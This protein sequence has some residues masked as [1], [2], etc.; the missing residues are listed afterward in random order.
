[1]D[2][3]VL[4]FF[5]KRHYSTGAFID[6]G[7]MTQK[8]SPDEHFMNLSACDKVDP[9]EF[10]MN[11]KV[12]RGDMSLCEIYIGK[13]F[14]VCARNRPLVNNGKV[15]LCSEQIVYATFRCTCIDKRLHMLDVR[16]WDLFIFGSIFLI[17]ADIHKDRRAEYHQQIRSERTIISVVKPA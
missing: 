5:E 7:K 16:K 11:G 1:M 6:H 10:S 3:R 9:C 14:T 4:F 15:K 8:Y 12:Q 13:M 2:R 17:K